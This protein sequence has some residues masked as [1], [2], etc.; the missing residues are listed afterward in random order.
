MPHTFEPFDS[1]AIPQAAS[2]RLLRHPSTATCERRCAG[3]GGGVY[4]LNAGLSTAAGASAQF[5]IW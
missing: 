5:L 4:L 2:D 1:S 3:T